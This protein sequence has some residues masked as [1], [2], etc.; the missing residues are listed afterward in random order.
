MRSKPD[1]NKAEIVA[2]LRQIGVVWIDQDRNAGFD[3]LALS[4]INGKH[5]I[6]IK[7]PTERWKLTPA[8]QDRKIQCELRGIPYN[9]VT[10]LEEAL[11][12]CG[13]G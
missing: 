12:V 7:N 11:M 3:G 4:I 9:I 13:Y 2:G 10:T 5:I 6:E 8:E 1:G